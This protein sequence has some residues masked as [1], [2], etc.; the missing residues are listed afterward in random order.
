LTPSLVL[1]S[2]IAYVLPLLFIFYMGLDVLLR[3]P[4][5]TEHRIFAA[6]NSCYFLI[7]LEE[8]VRFQLPIEYSPVLTATWF[9]CAGIAIPG[10]G[11]HFI[12]K[13]VGLDKR[14]PRLVYPY[15]FYAPLAIIPFNILGSERYISTQKF[16]MAGIW[17]LPVYNTAYYAAL[18]VSLAISATSII[19]MLKSRKAA[20]SAEQKSMYSLLLAS[21]IMTF[22]WIVVFGYFNYGKWLPPYPY[23]YGGIVWCFFLRL[24]MSKYEFLNLDIQRYAKFLISVLPPCSC[25][26]LPAK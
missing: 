1:V 10:L 17:K 3:N 6:I 21:V 19:I 25:C 9:S 8:F 12:V 23:L 13:I 18:T 24:I 22:A 15:I 26:V 7:I 11:V 5:K 14:M 2:I 16:V 4:K 20:I